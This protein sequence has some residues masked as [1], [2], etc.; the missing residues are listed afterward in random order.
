ME[1]LEKLWKIKD[2]ENL[3]DKDLE[4]ELGVDRMTIW[5]WRKKGVNPSPLAMERI[6]EFLRKHNV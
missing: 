1:E 2:R 3:S 4:K 6:K 5:V